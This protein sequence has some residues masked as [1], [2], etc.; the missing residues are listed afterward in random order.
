MYKESGLFG[1]FHFLGLQDSYF[2]L[3]FWQINPKG[4]L[5]RNKESQQFFLV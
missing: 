2:S 4:K 3:F 5:F 1:I